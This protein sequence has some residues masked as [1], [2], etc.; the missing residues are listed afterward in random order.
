MSEKREGFD[1][2][3]WEDDRMRTMLHGPGG[4]TIVGTDAAKHA[5]RLREILREGF[6]KKPLAD[7]GDRGNHVVPASSSDDPPSPDL[8]IENP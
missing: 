3:A 4:Y 8:T 7:P 5:E 2:T 1:I 6:T